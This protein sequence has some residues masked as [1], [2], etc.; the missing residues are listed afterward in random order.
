[1]R[2]STRNLQHTVL[3]GKHKRPSRK[4]RPAV[5]GLEE[6]ALLSAVPNSYVATPLVSDIHH[7]GLYDPRLVN[8]WDINFPQH[9]GTYP[10][11][12]VADQA[13][14][15]VTMYQVS[16]RGRRIKKSPLTVKIP[17]DGSS[18]PSGPTGVVYD[19]H[20]N[21]SFT[22]R[23]G[24]SVTYTYIFDTLQGTIEGYNEDSKAGK[25]S[26]KIVVPNNPSTTEY[27]GL[28]VGQASDGNYYI[29][30]ANDKASPGID[31]Y[32]GSFTQQTLLTGTFTGNFTDPCLPKGFTPYGVHYLENNLIVT[33]RAPNFV[34][35]AVAEFTSDG[36]FEKQ[37]DCDTTRSGRLQS[38]WGAAVISEVKAANDIGFGQFAPDVLVGNYSSGQI[39]A[40][41]F[42][43]GQF[44]GTVNN[45]VGDP[46]NIPGLRTI[47]F[48][49]GVGA[50]TKKPPG[51]LLFTTGGDNGESGEYGQ[52]TP[53]D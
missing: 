35:G 3:E 42:Q 13:T 26:A 16:T 19:A 50:Y 53:A 28:A 12:L 1:M 38:P 24:H 41:N 21:F 27:T 9:P 25:D 5:E 18:T 47:H 4:R 29:Y 39:D 17:T 44:D 10:P 23:H 40:Y 49:P 14:G 34:G 46:L 8:P 51:V 36:C 31:V 30:A 7:Y 48:G 43:T 2:H 37:F 11:E 45:T 20:K 6:R 15:V 22:G 52:I 33:Y 32:N